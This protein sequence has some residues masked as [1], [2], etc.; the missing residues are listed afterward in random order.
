MGVSMNIG[1]FGLIK[2]VHIAG[3]REVH[4]SCSWIVASWW[5]SDI[6]LPIL[7]SP[8]TFLHTRVAMLFTSSM[9]N[10]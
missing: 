6:N 5:K 9:A 3:T 10:I 7:G 2:E 8:N 4:G 1:N